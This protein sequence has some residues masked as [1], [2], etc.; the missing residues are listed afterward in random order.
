MLIH[1]LDDTECQKCG[2]PGPLDFRHSWCFALHI[3]G[4][5]V[6]LLPLE[7]PDDEWV[8]TDLAK[9][10]ERRPDACFDEREKGLTHDYTPTLIGD[11]AQS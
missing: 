8:E 6:G 10:R 9:R 5:R 7:E 11:E 3:S 4:L 2:A 1:Y